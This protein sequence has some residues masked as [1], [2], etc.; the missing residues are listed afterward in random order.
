MHIPHLLSA[1]RPALAGTRSHRFMESADIN[2]AFRELFVPLR[3]SIRRGLTNP[4]QIYG[5][6]MDSCIPGEVLGTEWIPPVARGMDD[7]TL[8]TDPFRRA[9]MFDR[10]LGERGADPLYAYVCEMPQGA[11]VAALCPVLCVELASSD[12]RHV[13]EYPIVA[14]KGWHRRDVIQVSHRSQPRHTRP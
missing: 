10:L 6:E 2:A 9:A 7:P 1:R 13:C 3:T 14:G 4:G 12:G 11:Q 5:I 8:L